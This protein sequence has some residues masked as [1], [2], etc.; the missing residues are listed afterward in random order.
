MKK[1][2][3]IY[4]S[5]GT[6]G[7]DNAAIMGY[8]N[9][10]KAA[11]IAID[12]KARFLP[13]NFFLEKATK[14]WDEQKRK[15]RKA[16]VCEVI[17]KLMSSQKH[18]EAE[19]ASADGEITQ[20]RFV[21]SMFCLRHHGFKYKFEKVDIVP[22][23]L[24]GKKLP[25]FAHVE[26][27]IVKHVDGEHELTE[28]EIRRLVQQRKSMHIHYLEKDNRWHC[29]YFTF[30]DLLGQ[31]WTTGHL[32]YCSSEW[33]RNFDDVLRELKNKRHGVRSVH[34]AFRLRSGLNPPK[35]E[36]GRLT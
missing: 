5:F 15:H 23:D 2:K 17:K 25:F 13:N 34:V 12:P 36:N 3:Y 24:K 32:H 9:M 20:E 4:S 29:F 19:Q 26:N 10:L 27:D 22:T 28:S 16:G 8:F 18:K 14:W 1:E 11:A 30:S 21:D 35:V 7:D 31:H 6:L 33:H